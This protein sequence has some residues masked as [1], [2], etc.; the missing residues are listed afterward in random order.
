MRDRE[1]KLGILSLLSRTP[2]FQT[3]PT[4]SLCPT[5]VWRLCV[6]LTLF[7]DVD[8]LEERVDKV[9]DTSLRVETGVGFE[10]D[11]PLLLRRERTHYYRCKGG[12]GWRG[13]LGRV[14]VVFP[15]PYHSLIMIIDSLR[16]TSVCRR[17]DDKDRRKIS[18]LY[19][20]FYFCFLCLV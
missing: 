17:M 10:T 8:P 20:D 6:L 18:D 13:G 19:N 3:P 4:D 12:G 15:P 9:G 5:P 16:G 14:G 2:L 7:V 11:P 1:K